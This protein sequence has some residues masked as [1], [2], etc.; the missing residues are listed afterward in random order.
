MSLYSSSSTLHFVIRI[1]YDVI[2]CEQRR[3]DYQSR[4]IQQVIYKK[5]SERVLGEK[6]STNPSVSWEGPNH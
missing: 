6:Y 4:T 2:M 5:I 3:L 1:Q